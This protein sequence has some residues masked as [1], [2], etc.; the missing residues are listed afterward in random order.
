MERNRPDGIYILS[1]V[2]FKAVQDLQG[3][4]MLLNCTAM[5]SIQCSA[6]LERCI[7]IQYG[8][9]EG[10]ALKYSAV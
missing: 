2:M 3:V 7:A 6:V 5:L 4:W 1:A 10:S 9:E 8:V